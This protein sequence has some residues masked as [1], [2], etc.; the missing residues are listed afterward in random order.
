MK[1]NEINTHPLQTT[2][3]RLVAMGEAFPGLMRRV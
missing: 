1:Q 3:E 2:K